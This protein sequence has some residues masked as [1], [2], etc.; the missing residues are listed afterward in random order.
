[1]SE[2]DGRT[3]A[4]SCGPLGV[5]SSMYRV[6]RDVPWR[7]SDARPLLLICERKCGKRPV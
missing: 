3:L 1:M 5:G 7:A 2:I 4:T 6:A